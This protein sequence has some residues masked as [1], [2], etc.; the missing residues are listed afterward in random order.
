MDELNETVIVT[1]SN[2]SNASLGSVDA[3]TYTITDNDG[4]PTID[5]G[6]TASSGAED[7][8]SVALTVYLSAASSQ[9]VTVNYAVTGTA[10]GS[11]TDFTLANGTLT[12]S[13]GAT[14]GTITIAGIV[15]D[16]LAEVNETVIITLSGPSNAVLGNDSVHTYTIND[17][18]GTPTV[19]FSTTSSTDSESVATR[20]IFVGIPFATSTAIQVDYGVTGGTAG[21]GTD[22]SLSSGSVTI[23]EGATTGTILIPSIVDDSADEA[24]ETI[25]ITLSNPTGAT[26]GSDI[27]HT[28]VIADND[29]PPVID[30]NSTSSNG[31]ESV[32]SAGLTIDLSEASNKNVTVDYSISGTATGS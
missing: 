1:L 22:F 29:S 19:A 31:A 15:D 8:S 11:G 24:D 3:H 13:A 27:V 5:F 14:S 21:S 2:P 9:N 12:I 32:S 18:D 16:E 7:I 23:E 20:S 10:T 26:L 25:I 6:N 30:F 4:Q 28:A 17:N